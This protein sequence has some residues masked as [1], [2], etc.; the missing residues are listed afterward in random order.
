MKKFAL[1]SAMLAC[2]VLSARETVVIVVAHPDD[3]AG[4]S[5][6]MLLLSEKYDVK[7]V[8]FTRGENGLGEAGYRDGSTARLREQEEKAACKFLNTEPVFTSAVNYKGLEAW[9]D[10]KR[11]KELVRLFEMW[12][13]RAVFLHWPL[14]HNVD[15]IT[16]TAAAMHALYLLKQTPYPTARSPEIYFH[17]QENQSRSFHPTVYV[18]VGSVRAKKEALI[19][20]YVSQDAPDILRRKTQ[21]DICRGRRVGVQYAEAFSVYEG[22]VR[23]LGVLDE[24]PSFR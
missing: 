22:S 21:N 4:P 2:G 9:A 3:L 18:D 7:V 1:L 16:S 10:E 24:L 6:T 12:K 17:E 8:D 5:G 13:P 19:S 11:T 23:G 20:C 15:H 14:D